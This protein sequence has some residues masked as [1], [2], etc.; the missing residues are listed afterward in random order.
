MD[1]IIPNEHD[2]AYAYL[3]EIAKELGLKQVS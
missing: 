1:G 2:A 3:L